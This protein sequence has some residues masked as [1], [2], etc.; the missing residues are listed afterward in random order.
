MIG[1]GL[2]TFTVFGQGKAGGSS[3]PVSSVSPAPSA[4][5][6]VDTVATVPLPER[7]ALLA[8]MDAADRVKFARLFNDLP[9]GGQ[10]NAKINALFMAW[11]MVDAPAAVENAKALPTPNTRTVALEAVAYGMKP[12]SSSAVARLLREVKTESLE[13]EGKE[14]ILGLSIVKWSQV[15]PAAAAQFLDEV[16]PDAAERLARPGAG[17][18]YLLTTTKGV[19]MNWGGAAPEAALTWFQKKGHPK[20]FV[21]VQNV[22]LGWWRKDAK[23]AAAYVSA[24]LATDGERQIAGVLAAPMA[25]QNPRVALEWTKWIGDERLRRRTKRQIADAWATQDPNAASQ[26]AVSLSGEERDAIITIVAAEWG[27]SSPAAAATWIDSLEGVARDAAISGYASVLSA[28]D[29]K[30]ALEWAFKI[31]DVKEKD[32]LTRAIANDWL[33]E[34]P[35][36]ARAWIK[37]SKLPEAGKKHLLGLD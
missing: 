10:S 24:H 4:K 28:K 19:A 30:S 20:N 3:A 23:A 27:H 22:I 9:A 11:G 31:K 15:D 34:K 35:D 26:W 7:S 6:E 12:E 8:K 16:Y 14:R 33:R 29:H 36:E 21:A 5:L 37:A 18:G 32:R 13:P 1:F 2:M 17:D 25:D